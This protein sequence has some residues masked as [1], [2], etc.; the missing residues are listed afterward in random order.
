MVKQA[1]PLKTKQLSLHKVLHI[2]TNL[3]FIP[4]LISCS[5]RDQDCGSR[6]NINCTHRGNCAYF[7]FETTYS[8]DKVYNLRIW[9]SK[10]LCQEWVISCVALRQSTPKEVLQ[11][12]HTA[13]VAQRFAS[14]KKNNRNCFSSTNSLQ[15]I[16]SR[17]QESVLFRHKTPFTGQQPRAFFS[18]CDTQKR[19]EKQLC[20][21]LQAWPVRLKCSGMF[22]WIRADLP[23][24]KALYI[25]QEPELFRAFRSSV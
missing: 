3:Y 23:R 25:C 16:S 13:G 1:A 15:Q 4:I 6:L 12:W 11:P 10:S 18:S 8:K 5:L 17:C 22:R 2:C 20:W 19:K 24:S 14:R 21:K 7:A 9:N